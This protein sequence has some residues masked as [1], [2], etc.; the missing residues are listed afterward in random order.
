MPSVSIVMAAMNEEQGIGE[1]LGKIFDLFK[2]HRIDGEVVVADSSSDKTPQIARD[3]GARVV[4]PDK[5]GYGHALVYGIN[6]ARGRY[7]VMGDADGTYNYADI[8]RLLEP[9]ARGE[10]EMVIGS[11]FRGEI[12]HGAMPWLHRYIGNPVITACLNVK[13]GTHISDAH[14]GI[15]AFTREAWDRTEHKLIPQDFCSELL[16]QMAKNKARITEIPV[17]YYPRKGKIKAGTLL[18][19]WRCFR[20]LAVHILLDR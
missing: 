16:K 2:Q 18:H 4:T 5:L 14:S 6:Q 10:A 1:C 15:R 12:K 3:M 8:P 9:L 20:Y 11:R 7:I 13:L 19:G 17:V